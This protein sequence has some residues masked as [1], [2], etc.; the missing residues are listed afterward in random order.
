MRACEKTKPIVFYEWEINRK[1]IALR[2]KLGQ[3]KFWA[4][5]TSLVNNCLIN[6][7]WW[8][9]KIPAYLAT[10]QG[11]I[12][13]F[14]RFFQDEISITSYIRKKSLYFQKLK[15][16]PKDFFS[17]SFGFW[18]IFQCLYNCYTVIANNQPLSTESFVKKLQNSSKMLEKAQFWAYFNF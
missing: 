11:F 10:F 5:K 14:S 1:E 3:G 2:K 18:A 7:L 6:R 4:G 15:K 17:S 13:T 9:T 16:R 12:S 8:I